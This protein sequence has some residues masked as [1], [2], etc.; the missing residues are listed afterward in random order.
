MK[1]NYNDMICLT[2]FVMSHSTIQLGWRSTKQGLLCLAQGYNTVPP[3]K[4][5]LRSLSLEPSTLPLHSTATTINISSGS[6]LFCK[7]KTKSSWQKYTIFLILKNLPVTP[8]NTKWAILYSL[9]CMIGKCQNEKGWASS[10]EPKA[11]KL[12]CVLHR[13]LSKTSLRM[14]LKRRLCI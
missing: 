4:P 8:S 13:V 3:A 2:W 7:D 5:N 1:C 10:G 12:M 9:K 11:L 14:W 6:A